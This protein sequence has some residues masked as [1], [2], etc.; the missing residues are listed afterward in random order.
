MRAIVYIAATALVW[1]APAAV[2]HAAVPKARASAPVN[3]KLAAAVEAIGALD[4]AAL[5]ADKNY[6][7]AM[8][9]HLDR[10]EASSLTTFNGSVL[11]TIR[12]LALMT[13]ARPPEALAVGKALIAAGTEEPGVYSIG[14]LA[15]TY[16]K[17]MPA[18]VQVA[19]AA[20]AKLPPS[21][22]ANF[23]A[24][25]DEDLVLALL[26]ELH[27]QADKSLKPRFAEALLTLEHPDADDVVLRDMYRGL[28]IDRYLQLGKVADARALA[29]QIVE[30]DTLAKLLV[31]KRYD[32]LFEGTPDA[33][34]LLETAMQ[35]FD[36]ATAKR[37]EA[38]PD[39]LSRILGRGQALRAL[40]R[41]VDAVNLLLPVAADMKRVEAGGEKAFWIVN[42]AAYALSDLGRSGEAVALMEKLLAL[43][44]QKH[45][46]LISMA[47]NHGEML[48]SA[49]RFADA[50][51]H[52]SKLSESGK[53]ASPYG[54]MWIWSLAAC[55]HLFGN[56]AAAAQP[57]LDKLAK[58]SADNEAAHMRALLCAN[59]MTGAEKLLLHRL[60][61]E[62]AGGVLLRLQTFEVGAIPSAPGKLIDTRLKALR[63]RPAVRA[64]IAATGRILSLPLP[65]TYWGAY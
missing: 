60:K 12:M 31:A 30:P 21:A 46:A 59:D 56:D 17:D 40:G 58:N 44:L 25:A 51:A 28:V 15:A 13:L 35:S 23:R 63:E 14:L 62:D 7:R 4:E 39:D 22:R 48:T 32:P 29:R 55:G 41:D 45:P 6:A 34:R 1:A 10:I 9:V 64:A 27:P 36:T 38:A 53:L 18:V 65:K 8:L 50:V 61:G 52:E 54:Y 47:I 5:T 43:G 16:S 37:L 11:G 24:V 20:A 19:E 2:A 26:S 49:G 57:W 3:K 33:R 42:E